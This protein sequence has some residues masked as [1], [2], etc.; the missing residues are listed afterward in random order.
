MMGTGTVVNAVAIAAGG[1]LGLLAG[2]GIKVRYQETVIHGLSLCVMVLGLK[3][4]LAGQHT[5][6]VISGLVL[7]ILVG[8]ALNIEGKLEQVGLYLGKRFS[9]KGETGAFAKG[10][11]TTSLIYCVGAMAIVGSIQDGL[12][13]DASTLYTKAMIDGLSAIMYGTNMGAGVMASALSVF[14]YQGTL[15]LLSSFI[16]PFVTDAVAQEIS[17]AGGILIF[18]IG[19]TMSKIIAMRVGNMIPGLFIVAVMTYFFG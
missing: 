7:G 19:L 4:A 8:E 12:N 6:F 16:G 14:F 17:A 18:G 11:L 2:R 3:M 9:Q 13:G 5:L 10:F 1:A 15:T